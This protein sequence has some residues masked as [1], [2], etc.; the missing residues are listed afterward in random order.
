[1]ACRT[2]EEATSIFA[3]VFNPFIHKLELATYDR[4]K[5]VVM[6]VTVFPFRLLLLMIFLTTAWFLAVLGVYGMSSEEINKK[7]LSG[8]RKQ[9][10]KPF[11]LLMLRVMFVIGGWHWVTV[12]GKQATPKEAPI[13]TLAPHSSLFDVL[14]IVMLG[15]PSVVAKTETEN[16]PFFGALINFTQ[17]VYVT[18]NNPL[19][20]KHT[21][22]EIKKR[23]YSDGEW[24]QIVIFPEGTCTNRSCLISFKSGAFYPGVPVQ[25]VCI[26]YPNTLDFAT[27]TWNGPGA[28]KLLWLSLCQFQ[29]YCEIEYLPVY[30][31]NDKEKE[32]PRLYADNVRLVMARAL[33]LPVSCYSFDDL[34]YIMMAHKQSLPQTAAVIKLLKIRSRL[35]LEMETIPEEIKTLTNYLQVQG[36][37]LIVEGFTSAL[38][39]PFDEIVR[40]GYDAFVQEAV[41]KVDLLHYTCGLWVINSSVDLWT[42]MENIFKML[43][44]DGVLAVGESE[45]IFIMWLL[46]GI[47]KNT[48]G[49]LY[50]EI[51][52]SGKGVVTFETFQKFVYKLPYLKDLL[53]LPGTMPT[54]GFARKSFLMDK[55]VKESK[56]S[57]PFPQ[58]ETRIKSE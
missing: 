58:E 14:P 12:K 17:P 44:Q 18:R 50:T 19:S 25:P 27:W 1:M 56:S 20:R 57:L 8:W 40:N 2:L 23:A 49:T 42:R 51:N 28:L 29:N 15:G 54:D 26:K 34:Q 3:G 24:D 13:L 4:V 21:I 39:V 22:D 11:I 46:T 47:S 5:V 41:E 48:A 53:V 33:D 52:P 35:N 32:N 7:P 37:S 16:T 30:Q 6:T 31:P 10:L 9:Y 36:S 43:S 38:E 55:N 45:F